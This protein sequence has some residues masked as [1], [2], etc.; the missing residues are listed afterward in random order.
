MIYLDH[1]AAT[2]LAPEVYAAMLPYV[3]DRYFNAS[4]GYLAAKEVKKDIEA[5]RVTTAQVLGVRP[6][7]VVF[8][9]G[10]T[11]ANNLAINGIMQNYPDSRVL[12]GSIEHDSVLEPA[13]RYDYHELPALPAGTVDVETVKKS[14]DSQTVLVSVM[15]VNNELGTIQPLAEISKLIREVRR[16]RQKTG[17]ELP[18]YFHTDACQ[19]GNYLHLL[20]DKLGVDMMTLNAGKLYGPKQSG[21]LYVKAGISLIPQIL[22]GGQER[23]VRSGTENPASIVGFAEALS[24]AQAI[25]HEESKRLSS[26]RNLFIDQLRQNVPVAELTTASRQVIP[27][28]IHIRIP[29]WDNERLMMQLDEVG[30]I[31][32]SGSACSASSDEPSHVLKAIGLSDEQAQS[33]LRFTMGRSTTEKDVTTTVDMLAKM[34]V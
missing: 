29:G 4:A 8:T 5:A 15:Y 24:S 23:N 18:L 6:G 3:T 30:I 28:T 1:A 16:E 11:E 14:L 26:L 10:G 7:E 20:A 31:C 17:N 25:R 27:G 32:A 34:I 22:G 21:A 2:P 12:I 9:A 19:A 33:S 13:R